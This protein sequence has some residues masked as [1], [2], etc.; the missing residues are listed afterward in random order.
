MP[1]QANPYLA[2]SFIAEVEDSNPVL[3]NAK[4]LLQ[5]NQ[6]VSFGR[7]WPSC[8]ITLYLNRLELKFLTQTFVLPTERIQ[9]LQS[10][11][12]GMHLHVLVVHDDQG[13]PA[14]VKVIPHLPARWYDAFEAAG[15]ATEDESEFRSAK[16][17]LIRSENWLL[18]SE[19]M[20]WFVVLILAPLAIVAV[21]YCKSLF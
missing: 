21:Q 3:A 1:N 10:A 13:V 16:Q 14:T 9:A 4:P 18:F 20:F 19:G 11:G 12:K 2:P 15:I 17:Y 5:V 6:R 7:V 8:R